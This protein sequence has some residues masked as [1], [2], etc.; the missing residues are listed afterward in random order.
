M[1]ADARRMSSASALRARR[2]QESKHTSAEASVH[3][4]KISNDGKSC[5]GD[6]RSYRTGKPDADGDLNQ[7]E[8]FFTSGAGH[9]VSAVLRLPISADRQPLSSRQHRISG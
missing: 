2:S 6:E 9:C 8:A 5:D 1:P 7:V 3:S 4:S